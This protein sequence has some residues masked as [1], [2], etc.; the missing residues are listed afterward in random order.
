M[1]IM[2]DVYSSVGGGPGRR[3]RLIYKYSYI[4]NF[5]CELVILFY[6]LDDDDGYRAIFKRVPSYPGCYCYEEGERDL[7]VDAKSWLT[8]KIFRISSR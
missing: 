4:I 7:A 8:S 2:V 1:I 3:R 5:V 6:Y